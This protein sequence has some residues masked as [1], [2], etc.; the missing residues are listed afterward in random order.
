MVGKWHPAHN[1]VKRLVLSG[2]RPG[3]SRIKDEG[4]SVTTCT[5]PE[6]PGDVLTQALGHRIRV[7]RAE[8][9]WSQETLS[10]LTGLHRT[11]LSQVERGSLPISVIQLAEKGSFYHCRA[12]RRGLKMPRQNT[13]LV[14]PVV[15][16]EAVSRF[17]IRPALANPWNTIAGA[18]RSLL[19]QGAQPL[20]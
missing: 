7:L 15:I 6:A 1:E 18:C 20:A 4:G 10:A 19:K 12:A 16:Q 17:R 5:P 9:G 13:R 11:Y 2:A 8:H 14:H 3:P